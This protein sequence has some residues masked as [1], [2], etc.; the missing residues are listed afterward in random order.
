[1]P[2]YLIETLSNA[3]ANRADLDQAAQELPDQGLLW[4][5]MEI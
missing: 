5:L 1:M 2:L 3:F 4:L